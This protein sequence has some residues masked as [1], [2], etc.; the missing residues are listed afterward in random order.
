MA[1][2][3]HREGVTPRAAWQRAL[4]ILDQLAQPEADTVRAKLDA[5]DQTRP[6]DGEN[7]PSCESTEQ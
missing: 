2:L 1:W 4:T 3:G 5:L 7:D 6:E